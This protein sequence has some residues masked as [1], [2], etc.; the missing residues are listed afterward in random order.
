MSKPLKAVVRRTFTW[1][2]GIDPRLNAKVVDDF[3]RRSKFI[4]WLRPKK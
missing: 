1:K 2:S 3:R 4:R